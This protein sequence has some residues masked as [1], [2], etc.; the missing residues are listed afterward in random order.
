MTEQRDNAEF[1]G[2]FAEILGDLDSLAETLDRR[3]YPGSAWPVRRRRR[4]WWPIAVAAAAA[5]VIVAVLLVRGAAPPPSV[6]T[7][8]MAPTSRQATSVPATRPTWTVPSG[9]TPA[10]TTPATFAIPR[11]TIPSGGEAGGF[12]WH[13]PTLSFPASSEGNTNRDS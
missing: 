13:V 1:D 10:F 5:A 9:I 7:I 8:A 2:R 12:R 3:A 6:K 4:F 11:I